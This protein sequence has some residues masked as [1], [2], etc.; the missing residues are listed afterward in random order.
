MIW[1]VYIGMEHTQSNTQ[2]LFFYERTT[3]LDVEAI[4]RKRTRRN[5]FGRLTPLY[6]YSW[7]HG[8]HVQMGS[9]Y[10]GD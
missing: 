6:W 5:I 1:K 9:G 8:P 2:L 7:A 10:K 3:R 4:K